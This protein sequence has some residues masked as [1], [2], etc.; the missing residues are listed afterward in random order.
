MSL[1]KIG[2]LAKMAGGYDQYMPHIRLAPVAWTDSIGSVRERDQAVTSKIYDDFDLRVETMDMARLMIH[3]VNHEPDA[4]EPD[5]A[6]LG[7]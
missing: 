1:P 6:H 3:R 7:I 4:V 5:R 2:K